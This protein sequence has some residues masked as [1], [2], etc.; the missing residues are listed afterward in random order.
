MPQLVD[1]SKVSP[2]VVAENGIES[3]KFTEMDGLDFFLGIV[4]AAT[5]LPPLF[6][7]CAFIF[8]T[9]G[10]FYVYTYLVLIFGL[11]LSTGNG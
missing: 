7:I 9:F 3:R 10:T 2:E 8:F 11:A 6:S 1:N 4:G 5:I